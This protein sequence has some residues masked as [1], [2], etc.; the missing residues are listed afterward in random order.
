MLFEDGRFAA[1]AEAAHGL[2]IASLMAQ[3]VESLGFR[4]KTEVSD[5]RVETHHERENDQRLRNPPAE[6]QEEK[7]CSRQC[8]K[9]RHLRE[10]QVF[11][12]LGKWRSIIDSFGRPKADVDAHGHIVKAKTKYVDHHGAFNLAVV[13]AATHRLL[14]QSLN[15]SSIKTAVKSQWFR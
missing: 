8:P 4:V 2:A 6:N 1:L 9:R 5:N 3:R 10:F 12:M 11:V 13:V 14:S 7:E 15:K